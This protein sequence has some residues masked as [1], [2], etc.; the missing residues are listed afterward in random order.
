MYCEVDLMNT[1]GR[2]LL[3]VMIVIIFCNYCFYVYIFTPI[4]V[5]NDILLTCVIIFVILYFCWICAN[6]LMVKCTSYLF[7]RKQGRIT[8]K[9][10]CLDHLISGM[11]ILFSYIMSFFFTNFHIPLG[12]GQEDRLHFYSKNIRDVGIEQCFKH[13]QTHL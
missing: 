1:K 11:F 7:Y 12:A 6:E 2:N 13:I 5:Y 9:N 3:I 4:Y 10:C 8:Q